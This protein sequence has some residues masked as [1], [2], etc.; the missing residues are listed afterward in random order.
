MA[1]ERNVSKINL[2]GTDYLIKDTKSRQVAN[3]AETSASQAKTA[4]DNA[5]N[6][7]N[8][9]ATSASE[10][11]T[12]AGNAQT[13]ADNAATSA[14]E[15]KTAAANA[16]NTANTANGKAT[17]NSANITKLSAEGVVISYESKNESIKVTKGI[18]L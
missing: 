13:T 6:T 7:A 12:A 9:A 16:Q 18:S 4:A 8:N 5:Q 1:D 14:S 3:S 15:A 11:M 17:T 2:Y 10:A